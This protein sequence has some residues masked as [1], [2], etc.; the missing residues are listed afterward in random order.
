MSNKYGFLIN[1][2]SGRNVINTTL[3]RNITLLDVL[4]FD[5]EYWSTFNANTLALKYKNGSTPLPTT[6]NLFVV[7]PSELSTLP[8]WKDRVPDWFLSYDDP[9]VIKKTYNMT[10][11][12]GTDASLNYSD[13]FIRVSPVNRV[14]LDYTIK[15][16]ILTVYMVAEILHY[17]STFNYGIL[18]MYTPPFTPEELVNFKALGKTITLRIGLS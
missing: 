14:L 10:E 15:D 6:G 18:F 9:T 8:I 11:L 1:A 13:V 7:Q 4:Y 2:P 16:N 5:A 12:T 17:S 3:H